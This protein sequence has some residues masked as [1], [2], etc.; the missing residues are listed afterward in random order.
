[1][2]SNK[3]RIIWLKHNFWGK[4]INMGKRYNL[5]M[6][7]VGG[8]KKSVILTS[9]TVREW[10]YL[11]ISWSCTHLRLWP[12]IWHQPARCV[13]I[14]SIAQMYTSSKAEDGCLGSFRIGLWRIKYDWRRK[15]QWTEEFCQWGPMVMSY[16]IQVA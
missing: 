15:R 7:K 8:W 4:I 13:I 11:K 2:P 12:W 6:R 3:M 1:M 14:F 10:A 9:S 16:G 5:Y